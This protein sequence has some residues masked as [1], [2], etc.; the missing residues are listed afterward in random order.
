MMTKCPPIDFDANDPAQS[1]AQHLIDHHRD[2]IIHGADDDTWRHYR[3]LVKDASAKFGID[4]DYL[5]L[6][7]E[8]I[9]NDATR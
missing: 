7:T 3:R 2:S 8:D 6:R 9:L 4:A 5:D 1:I